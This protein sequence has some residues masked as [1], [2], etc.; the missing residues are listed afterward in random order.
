MIKRKNEILAAVTAAAGLAA[1]GLHRGLM[2]S[3]VDQGLLPR[4]SVHATALWCLTI[5]ILV[6]VLLFTRKMGAQGSFAEAFPACRLRSALGIAG[7]VVLVWVGLGDLAHLPGLLDCAAGVAMIAAGLCRGKGTQPWPGFHAL[8]CVNCMYRLVG[9]FRSWS[10]DP[11]LHD[12]VIQ[13]LA[14]VCLMQLSCHRACCDADRIRRRSTVV[15]GM[16][17]VY[18][19][20]AALSCPDAGFFLACGLWALGAVPSIDHLEEET[21]EPAEK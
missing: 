18:F 17:A 13:L 8:V 20:A 15:W 7:G 1:M 11:Q 6:F 10:A 16:L 4:N 9:S 19:C 5:G 14:M 3:L 2:A 12:Y 21:G